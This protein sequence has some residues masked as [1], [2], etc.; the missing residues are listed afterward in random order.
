MCEGALSEGRVSL[1]TLASI[2]ENFFWAIPAIPFAQ[3][4]YRSLQ[5]FYILNAQR[6]DFNLEA[7]VCLSPGARLDLNWWV[8]NIEKANGKMFFSARPR[9]RDFLGCIADR[10]GSGMQRDNNAGPLDVAR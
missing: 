5:R 6:V 2:Q 7:E 9:F 1:R 4:H 8:A 3:A 10:V